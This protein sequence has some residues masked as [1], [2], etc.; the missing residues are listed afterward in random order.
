MGNMQDLGTAS[1]PSNSLST[2]GIALSDWQNVGGGETGFSMPDPTNPDIVYSGNYAGIITK[3]D[4]KT[5]QAR[6]I[7]AYPFN[8][9]GHAPADL[10]YRFQWT[11][12]SSPGH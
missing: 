7:G 11:A 5:R 4:R 6:N 9:S 1:G 3:F 10:K 12:E 2:E 8:T